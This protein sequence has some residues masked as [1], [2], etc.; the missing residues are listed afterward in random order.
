MQILVIGFTGILGLVIKTAL[1]P[2]G[3]DRTEIESHLQFEVHI[4]A[5]CQLP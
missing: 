5:I 3:F 1:R 4:P 2:D